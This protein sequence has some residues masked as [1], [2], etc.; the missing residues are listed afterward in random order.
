M[1]DFNDQ[2]IA[3][4]RANKGVVG[5][6]FDGAHVLLLHTIG[7]RTGAERIKPLLYLPDGESFVLVGSAGGAAD[8][9]LWVANVEAMPEVTVE[10]GARTV[11]TR[12]TV[13]REG[14][15]R[16]RLYPRFVEYWPD[17]LEYQTHTDRQ[18]PLIHLAPVS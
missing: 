5:G 9:P 14:Q 1:S 16:E 6:H 8:E 17:L 7:R 18:F 12:P 3:E 10:V 13:L 2:V 11:T 15:E 4:F